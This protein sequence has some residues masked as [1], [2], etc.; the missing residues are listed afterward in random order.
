MPRGPAGEAYDIG[1][2]GDDFERKFAVDVLMRPG[3]AVRAS[4]MAGLGA[5]A[6]RL[7][8]DGLDG[9][10]ASATFGAAA[11]AAI[12]LLGI[13][14]K[15][16]RGVD[17]IADIVVAEDVAGTNYH[18]VGGLTGDA[19]PMRYLSWQRDAKEKTVFSSDSKLTGHT[20]WNESKTL[21]CSGSKRS[22]STGRAASIIATTS[23]VASAI[24]SNRVAWIA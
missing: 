20:N 18:K 11:E 19:L 22:L 21:Y 15:V 24:A 9:A 8:N 2:S 10:R 13:A 7:V 5:S 23:V 12:D 4:G 3:P 6:E 1:V 17:G 14:G 16:F